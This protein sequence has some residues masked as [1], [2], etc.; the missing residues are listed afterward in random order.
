MTCLI[1]WS[2]DTN[3]W[4]PIDCTQKLGY[5]LLQ[6][7]RLEVLDVPFYFQIGVFDEIPM[8]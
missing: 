7:Q 4:I 6:A 3:E 5:L 8:A 2:K 1:A